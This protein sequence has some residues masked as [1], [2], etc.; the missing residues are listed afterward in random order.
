MSPY[1]VGLFAATGTLF[2]SSRDE[3]LVVVTTSGALSCLLRCSWETTHTN[4]GSS[5][6]L[7]GAA[8]EGQQQFLSE[9]VWSEAFFTRAGVLAHQVLLDVGAQEQE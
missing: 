8:G 2:S 9:V 5:N 6:A 1:T 3:D 7:Y 4:V